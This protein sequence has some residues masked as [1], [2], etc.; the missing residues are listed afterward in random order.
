VFKDERRLGRRP[1]FKLN[2]GGALVNKLVDTGAIISFI[3]KKVASALDIEVSQ[4]LAIL[5]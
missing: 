4:D 5:G 1:V 2:I 3:P